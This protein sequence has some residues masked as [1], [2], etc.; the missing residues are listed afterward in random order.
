[1]A[2]IELETS[3]ILSHIFEIFRWNGL[4]EMDFFSLRVK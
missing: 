3:V 4:Q 2:E 1:M